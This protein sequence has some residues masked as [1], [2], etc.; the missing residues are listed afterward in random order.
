MEK[1]MEIFGLFIT[2]LFLLAG[3][4][5]GNQWLFGCIPGFIIGGFGLLFDAD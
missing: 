5:M 4:F 3:F 2:C 1:V